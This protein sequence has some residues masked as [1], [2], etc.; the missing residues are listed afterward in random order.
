VQITT[1][2]GQG[3]ILIDGKRMGSGAF[4]GELPIGSH[5]LVVTREGF[6]AHE[7]T[8]QVKGDVAFSQS[9]TLVRV[10][11]KADGAAAPEPFGGLYGGWMLFGAFQPAGTG[12]SFESNCGLFGASGCTGPSPAGVGVS[13]HAGYTWDPVGIELYGGLMIDFSQPSATYDGVV[14]AGSNAAL[15]GPPRTEN[16]R[17]LRYGGIGAI[18]A[19]AAFESRS[20]RVSVAAGPGFSIKNITSDR[21][22][23][24]TDGTNLTD[25]YRPPDITLASAALSIE[26]ALSF[27]ASPRFAMTTGMMF[28][29]E[30]AS[31]VTTKADPDRRVVGPMGL[32][33]LRT[34]EYRL[35][36]GAQAFFGPFLGM[37]FGP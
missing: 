19:R 7:E 37:T 29:F 14:R 2:D 16:W 15:T 27:R 34:P 3:E 24:T 36:T 6:V 20:F 11:T 5:K 25:D 22:M 10:P 17:V 23:A 28:W 30:S 35:A 33:P 31:T 8:I 21:Q 18:R 13:G 9:V 4:R 32:I 26:I 12:S 1:S